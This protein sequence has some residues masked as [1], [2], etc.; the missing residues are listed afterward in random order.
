MKHKINKLLLLSFF[1]LQ[2]SIPKLSICQSQ[3]IL[4]EF[5]NETIKQQSI[6]CKL[7]EV[8]IMNYYKAFNG[9]MQFNLELF[10]KTKSILRECYYQNNKKLKDDIINKVSLISDSR[11]N[12]WDINSNILTLAVSTSDLSIGEKNSVITSFINEVSKQVLDCEKCKEIID[13]YFEAFK[14]RQIFSDI[15][16]YKIK[17]LT[18]RCF[19]QLYRFDYDRNNNKKSKWVSECEGKDTKYKFLTLSGNIGYV[20]SGF[21][22][23]DFFY[24]PLNKNNYSWNCQKNN[25]DKRDGYYNWILLQRMGLSP[26]Y[27]NVPLFDKNG[28]FLEINDVVKLIPNDTLKGDFYFVDGKATYKSETYDPKD[29]IGDI[30][31]IIPYDFSFVLKN[32]FYDSIEVSNIN[33]IP[34]QSREFSENC[35]SFKS[36]FPK[37]IGPNDTLSVNGY[38]IPKRNQPLYSL[39][40]I[41]RISL[42]GIIGSKDLIYKFVPYSV[43]RNINSEQNNLGS[44]KNTN[45]KNEQ[46]VNNSSNQNNNIKSQPTQ[47]CKLIITKPKLNFTIVDDRKRCYCC[48]DYYAR[49]SLSDINEQKKSEELSYLNALLDKH[50]KDTNANEE[51]QKNDRG[52]LFD[53]IEK[54]YG[55]D[56]VTMATSMYGG[57]FNTLSSFL[58]ED[59]LN[60]NRKIYKYTLKSKYCST[61]CENDIRCQ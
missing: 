22:S 45:Q 58:G 59:P 55:I 43:N 34:I 5:K 48:P 47:V 12:D 24:Y 21:V 51:H 8:G 54:T 44:P 30:D 1:L 16:L 18:E 40:F 32:L 25:I 53:Y 15:M 17:D 61:R 19:S 46:I 37:K 4:K 36:Q 49:Y 9:G 57:I 28:N 7:C 26:I 14:N 41:F 20:P 42:N 33:I 10:S 13:T 23:S 56:I 6:E 3:D 31:R 35:I 60:K 11:R 29:K 52:K 27:Q 50:F 2:I 39:G 38:Y